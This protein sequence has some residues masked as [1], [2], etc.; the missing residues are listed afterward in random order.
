MTLTAAQRDRACGT[1]LGMAAG[2]ALGAGY[3]FGPSLA[4]DV[5]VEMIGGG[6]GAFERGEWTD[7]TSMA[8]PIAEI[9]ATG[10][11]LRDEQAQDYIVRRWRE[12]AQAPK[13]IGNQ[14]RSVL[15]ALGRQGIS[16][17]FAR[18]ES[19]ALHKRTGHTAGNGSLMR[20]APVALA[21]LADEEA[22]AEAARG[23]SDLTHHDPDAGDACVLW[24]YAIRHAVLTGD[25][26]ARIGLDRL[27]AARRDLWASRLDEAE[28]SPPSHFAAKNGW[29]VAALQ[30]A[31]SA[32]VNTPV[33]ADDYTSGAFRADHLRLA[34]EDAVRGGHD[35]DTVAAIAGG[36]LGAAYGASAV[37]SRWRLLLHGWPGLRTRGLVKLANN[38]V[39]K[40]QP[41][42]FDYTY[43]GF[44]EARQPVRHPY[45][46]K[47][48]IGGVAALR[49]L[50]EEVDAVVSL[51]RVAD[52][53]LPVGMEHLDVRLVDAEGE[54][55]NLDFVLL[56][57]VRAIEQLRAAG[58]TVFV[59]CVQ[60]YSR[61]PTIAAAYGACKR[62]VGID[63]AL[64]DV[65]AVLPGANPNPEFRKALRGWHP[66]ACGGS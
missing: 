24:C 3:E 29:V 34:L 4:P 48:W 19:A 15:S 64:A 61:T 56:D 26:D 22:L 57:T 18:E 25:I 65:V 27:D 13:G 39:D 43:R 49:S 60:A 7:D 36:L 6:L 33:P 32:I 63:E 31:W 44:P 23:L 55:D 20:T 1:L 38:I 62:G 5:P 16:A 66:K 10:A 46:E 9:A 42:T 8:V 37:P 54:N 35:T 40:G 41:D 50:P 51:C 14:T 30:G 59:H 58:R 2:D 52:E 12:W 45:D 21:Y 53:H 17:K 47:V 28:A 11:D